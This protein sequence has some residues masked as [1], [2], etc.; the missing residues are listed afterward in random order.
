MLRTQNYKCT[1]QIQINSKSFNALEIRKKNGVRIFGERIW[2]NPTVS[3]G[4]RKPLLDSSNVVIEQ[5][6]VQLVIYN[7]P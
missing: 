1:N 4:N 6:I 2:C 3:H 7:T 5:I